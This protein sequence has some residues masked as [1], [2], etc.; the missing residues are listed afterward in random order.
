MKL[1]FYILIT[2]NI[3]SAQPDSRFDTF[4]W[5]VYRKTGAISSITEGYN[6]TYFATGNAGIL[7]MQLYQ[8]RFDEPITTAQGLT[9]NQIFAIHFDQS[10]G[11][12]WAATED[13]IDYSYN[14]EGNWFHINLV[15]AGLHRNAQIL[16]I[17][18][19]YN[20]VWINAGSTFL[21]LDKVSGIVMGLLPLPDEDNINWSSK[22]E[23]NL[24]LPTKLK[25]YAIM[26][27]WILNYN[28]FI[29]PF[30]KST[31]PTTYHFGTHNKVY[32]GLE[33]GIILIGDNQMETLQPMIFG[34]NNDNITALIA[35]N[36]LWIVGRND[37]NSEGITRYNI[38][39]KYFEHIDFENSINFRAQSFYSILETDKEIWIGG[40][41]TISVYN[42]KK[43]YWRE[44][45]EG[46]GIPNGLVTAMVDDESSVWV[47]SNRGLV[48]VSK[49]NK[50][51]KKIDVENKLT[52][53]RI[54]DLEFVNGKLWVA[55]DNHLLIYDTINNTFTD[56]KG[57]GDTDLINT[58]K[59]IFRN[60]TDLFRSKNQIYAMTRDG[61]LKYDFGNN[62]W[63]VIVEPSAF[64]DSKVNKLVVMHEHCFLGAYDS[65][66]Q[67]DLESGLSQQ[68]DF[69]FIGSVQ[70]M[71]I[72]DDTLFIGSDKGLIKYLWKKNL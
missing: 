13:F 68:Y 57:I 2:L 32:I 14:A 27:G 67:I 24:D 56:F 39:N 10:T 3:L 71:Y 37:F 15:D 29:D 26:D 31:T 41:S 55:T 12:L 33:D 63:S 51:I 59:N 40:N 35:K 9:D 43:D 65:I 30:G 48:K 20:Y 34:L 11:I 8:D 1:L 72:Q 61:V 54:N 17:G 70:D 7:R 58:R 53:Y 6:F 25:N 64:A 18:S 28:Q 22:H 46:Q 36:D 66:W 16:Q 60:F 23:Y 69:S 47:G 4:D 52:L 45:N 62:R 19:S 49:I 38:R 44:I 42:K 21:K 5:V 50:H